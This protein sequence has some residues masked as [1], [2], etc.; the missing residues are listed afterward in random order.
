[1]AS[2][3][4]TIQDVWSRIDSMDKKY[5]T[6]LFI[7]KKILT[8]DEACLFLDL[9]KSYLYKL[10]SAG[11]LPFSKPNGKKIYFDRQDLETWALANRMPGASERSEKAAS[12]V[13][14]NKAK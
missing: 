5:A 9:E 11:V 8:A 3:K 7:T 1:M 12:Y 10:T 13:A 14:L 2:K 6:Q 4:I